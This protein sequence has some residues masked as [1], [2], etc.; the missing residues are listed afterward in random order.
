M[1]QRRLVTILAADAVEYSRLVGHDEEGALALFKDC[2]AIIHDR[3]QAHNGRVFGGAGDSVIAAF[4]SPVEAMRCAIEIQNGI[5]QLDEKLSKDWRMLFRVGLNLGD[6]VVEQDNLLGDAV[7]V[8]ARLEG[9]SEPGGICVSGSLYEQVKHLPNLGFQD[10]GSKRLK[11][12]PIPV[13]VYSIKGVSSARSRQ[14]YPKWGLPIAI[15]TLLAV[16][17]VPVLWK[18][19]S[20]LTFKSEAGLQVLSP[21]Q[22]SIAVLPLDNLTGDPTQEYFSDGITNDITSD[23]SK[24]SGLMVIANNSAATFKGKPTKVQDIG[25]ALRVRYVLEGTVQKTPDRLRINAQ[26]IDAET[27]YHLWANRYDQTLGDTFSVQEDITKNIVTALAVKI[28]NA[29]EQRSNAKLTSSMSAYDY[30]LQGKAIWAD[31]SKVTPEGNAE[32][33]QLFQKAIELDPKYSAAY[34]ELSYVNVRAAQNGWT[35]DSKA[36]LQQ[37]EDL[38][39]KALSLSD[40]FSG[41]WYLAI[42][43]WNKGD[44]DKSYREYERAR[45]INPNDPDLAADMAE[46]LVYGGEPEKAIEQIEAA[47]R[48]NPFYDYWYDWNEGRARYMAGQYQE[49][50]DAIGRINSP[51]NDVRLITAASKAQLGDIP[52]AKSIM[53]EFSKIDPDWSIAKSA[54]YFYRKDRDRQHWLDGLRKAGLKEL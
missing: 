39:N 35:D 22:P 36:S 19:K 18:Y 46:A 40:N 30:Y 8:A 28:T 42:I 54:A 16:L 48:R 10:L 23:L 45:Q 53:A 14:R 6:A 34:A 31:S 51:P 20:H 13:H 43:A 5:M 25:K 26:L 3:V 9:M 4:H 15:V 12:I 47:K 29:E 1:L 17:A 2:A 11:N 37:A 24:F 33:R 44:F 7:N 27:G 38:A 21:S 50:I 52:A 41:H 49:A 32:A